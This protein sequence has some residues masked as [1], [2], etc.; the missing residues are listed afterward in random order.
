MNMEIE[1]KFETA[2]GAERAVFEAMHL[3]PDGYQVMRAPEG[4]T[5]HGKD[6]VYSYEP[7]FI[8]AGPDGRTVMVEVK[9]P[10]SLSWSNLARFVQIDRSAREAGTGF[11]VLVPGEET[12][13]PAMQVPE[14]S[15]IN[16]ECANDESGMADAVL[17]ALHTAPDVKQAVFYERDLDATT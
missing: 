14:F 12:E 3:L 7:D 6:M 9:R 16:I 15:E 2:S 13:L 1:S 8:V 17:Q 5:V 10:G 4:L 11:L